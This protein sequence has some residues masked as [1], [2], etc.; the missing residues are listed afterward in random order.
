MDDRE[1]LERAA[2]AAGI[3]F[4]NKRTRTGSPHL[5][6]GPGRGWW[7]PLVDRGQALELAV[8]RNLTLRGIDAGVVTV[9]GNGVWEECEVGDDPCDATCRAIVRAAAAQLT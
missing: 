2:S 4:N 9:A 1:L 5:Y 6:L 3:Y 7:N 8:N